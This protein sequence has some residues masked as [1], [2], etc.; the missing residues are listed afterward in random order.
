[1]RISLFGFRCLYNDI[2]NVVSREAQQSEV[3]E[4]A[5][6]DLF[7]LS[8]CLS[9]EDLD[10]MLHRVCTRV[11]AERTQPEA[12]AV[13][14]AMERAMDIIEHRFSEPE[15]S[16]RDIAQELGISDSKLSVEFKK[17][18]HMTPLER[19]TTARMQR[20]RR[21]LRTTDMPVKDIALECGYYDI[22]GFN[23]RFKAYTGMTLQ[24]Y[25]FLDEPAAKE[26]N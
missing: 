8:Q 1:M 20:A 11:L 19:I 21:L 16:V 24:Q 18:Y 7:K 2:L 25:K 3:S 6:Y 22:S 15:L 5:V 9:M 23:R 14:E 26:E 4:E 10:A 12:Q 13:P 17:A